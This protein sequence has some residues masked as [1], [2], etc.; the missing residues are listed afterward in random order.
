MSFLFLKTAVII[1][2]FQ[3]PVE[4]KNSGFECS[5]ERVHSNFMQNNIEPL[6]R[7]NIPARPKDAL[8]GTSFMKSVESLT[9]AEREEKI[10]EEISKGNIPQFLRT[11]T[12]LESNFLDSKGIIHNVIYEVMPDYLAI[13]SDEDYCRIP[14][15]PKTAQ[16]TA[17]L[18]GAVLPT[19]KLVDD[20]YQHSDIKLKPVTYV[21][22]GNLSELVPKFV[23]H[24]NDIEMQL[25]NSEARLGQLIAGTKK[26]VVISNKIMDPN[27]PNHVVIYGWHKLDG[28]PIQ[29]L[30]NIHFDTYVDYSHGIRLLKSEIL[31]DGEIKNIADILKEENLYRILS[32]ESEPMNKPYY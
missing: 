17:D 8:S 1:F 15:G 23:K 14:M 4:A 26:D 24:N 19:S 25:K 13:G 2:L 18:F 32:D 7:L 12:K 3:A 22:V 31:L 20:I 6:Q 27:R 5:E 29:P 11:L 16:K 21:P 28:L 30:T 9:F 10:F